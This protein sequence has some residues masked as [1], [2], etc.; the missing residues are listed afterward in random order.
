MKN[1]YALLFCCCLFLN[2][3]D[4]TFEATD[5][6]SSTSQFASKPEANAVYDNSYKGIYKGVVTGDISGA[7][8]VNLFNDDQITAKLITND[9]KTYVLENVPLSGG[10]SGSLTE[11]ERKFL[12]ENENITFE[13]KLDENGSNISILNFNF[14]SNDDTKI[15][16]KKE[17]SNSLIKCYTGTFKNG[18]EDGSVNFTSDGKM[19]V[20]GISHKS[21]SSNYTEV[22]GQISLTTPDDGDQVD[23]V[24]RKQNSPQYVLNANLHVGEITGFLTNHNFDGYW[25]LNDEKI[26][27]WNANRLL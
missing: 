26:G 22:I 19:K 6:T 16:M 21:N 13:F 2:C 8:Y 25:M 4:D 5:G 15:C 3:T 18:E 12:F 9:K 17:T 27:L 23:E 14:Y 11:D 20:S 1:V 10:D 24:L 7:L